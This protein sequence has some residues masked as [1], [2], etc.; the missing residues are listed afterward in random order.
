MRNF[1]IDGLY[2]PLICLAIPLYLMLVGCPGNV[3]SLRR[4]QE[5]DQEGARIA[6]KAYHEA[7]DSLNFGRRDSSA[8]LRIAFNGFYVYCTH[9]A[10]NE[11]PLAKPAEADSLAGLLKDL[12]PKKV[13]PE[14][15][16]K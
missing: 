14:S 9:A 16:N 3:H 12:D 1:N 11:K 6:G 15:P 7:L 10:N 8:A 2:K 4:G 13:E 5:I